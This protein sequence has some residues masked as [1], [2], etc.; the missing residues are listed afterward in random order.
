MKNLRSRR[1]FGAI[2]EDFH[3][4]KSD[5]SKNTSGYGLHEYIDKEKRVKK[6][7]RKN[8]MSPLGGIADFCRIS[9]LRPFFGYFHIIKS[10]KSKNVSGYG[11]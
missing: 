11:L 2:F 9:T 4:I 6:Y 5:K 8:G 10:D 7:Y 3:I 1:N